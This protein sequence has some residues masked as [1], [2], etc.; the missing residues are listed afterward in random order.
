LY[1]D[2]GGSDTVTREQEDM[3]P[4]IGDHNDLVLMDAFEAAIKRLKQNK[5]PGTDGITREAI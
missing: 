5:N 3:A 1:K 4:P 2:S